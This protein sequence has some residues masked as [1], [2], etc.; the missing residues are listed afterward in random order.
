MGRKGQ[1]IVVV[2]TLDSKDEE[3]LYLKKLIRRRGHNALIMDVGIGG[4]VSSPADF[5]R[6]EVALATGRSL[7]EIRK[8]A[9]TH[10][11]VLAAMAIGAKTLIQDLINKKKIDGLLSIGGGLGTTQASIIM[12]SLPLSLPKLI[13]S[14][15]AFVPGAMGGEMVSVDQAM[16]QSAADLWGL[17]TITR[18]ALQRAA[19]AICGMAEEQEEK[20]IGGARRVA[21]STLGL[22]SYVDLCKSLLFEKGYEPVVFHS[23]GTGSLE[24][25]VRQG[26]FSGTLDLSCYELVSHVCGGIVKGD[27]EKFT[28]ACEKG[29]PQVIA[30]GGLDFFP[31]YSYQPI[32]AKFRKRTVFSQ[33][34]VNLIKTSPQEQRT[35]AALLAEKVNKAR[36]STTVLVPLKGFSKLDCNKGMPFYE[37]GAGQRFARI[38]KK[39]VSNPLVQIEEIGAHIND[40][41]FAERAA[42]LL[43]SRMS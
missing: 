27:E 33:G 19:G 36:G 34:M 16:M 3:A 28:A 42:G 4:E 1:N 11:E 30:S 15:V 2:V 43:L 38:L 6:E 21:I 41:V 31:L 39:K 8:G 12:P 20:E 23:I 22:H 13:L 14:T 25:L 26:Y 9:R 5:T 7:E 10:T 40:R 18:I 37:P 29:I 35:V 17:N 32:P 24:K